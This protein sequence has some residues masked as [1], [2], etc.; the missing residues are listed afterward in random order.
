M[1]LICLDKGKS[2]FFSSPREKFYH[3]YSEHMTKKEDFLD[4]ESKLRKEYDD[5]FHEELKILE[6][7]SILNR[8]GAFAK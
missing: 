8:R 1:C 4:P 6:Q 2:R 3:L 5:G 7:L